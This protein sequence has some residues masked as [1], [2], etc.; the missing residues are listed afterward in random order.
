MP[1]TMY[2]GKPLFH[3]EDTGFKTPCW[4]WDRTIVYGYGQTRLVG[5]DGYKNVAIYAH[6][7]L[8]QMANGPVPKGKQLDHLCRIR[9]CCRPDH[10]EVVTNAENVRRSPLKAKLTWD[11]VRDIRTRQRTGAE[12]AEQYEVSRGTVW[13]IW[14][15]RSW[16]AE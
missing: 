8:W 16:M 1:N 2:R 3:F 11:A 14:Q 5:G 4:L 15:E 10:L 9:R 12:Y 13:A 6:R 7:W